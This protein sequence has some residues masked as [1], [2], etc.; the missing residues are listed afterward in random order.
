MNLSTA[1]ES[2]STSLHWL[3]AIFRRPE[4]AARE[5]LRIEQGSA[6]RLFLYYH[7]P[8]LA[9][10][11][12]AGLLCPAVHLGAGRFSFGL[13]VVA[14][15]AL[16]IGALA[17]AVLFDQVARFAQHPRMENGVDEKRTKNLALFLH[18]PLSASG[19]FFLFHPLLGFLMLLA[20]LLYC[21]WISIET[22]AMFYESSRARVL[23]YMINAALLG[24]APLAL[25]TF[26]GNLLRNINFITDIL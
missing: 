11:P 25:L 21:V 15:L 12:V 19:I 8:L 24:V 26:L 10:F 4:A 9:I 16:V 14:P 6:L 5:F 3:A 18:L 20:A 17:F 22:T 1:L 23:V 13:Q 7:L 2:F